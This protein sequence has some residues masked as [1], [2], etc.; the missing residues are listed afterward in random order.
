MHHNCEYDQISSYHEKDGTSQQKDSIS[1]YKENSHHCPSSAKK[2]N[3][4]Y[5]RDR[6]FDLDKKDHPSHIETYDQGRLSSFDANLVNDNSNYYLNERNNRI[7]VTAQSRNKDENLY[8][9]NTLKSDQRH[10]LHLL[11]KNDYS[12][13]SSLQRHCHNERRKQLTSELRRFSQM[14]LTIPNHLQ[15]SNSYG[16]IPIKTKGFNRRLNHSDRKRQK[17]Y[18]NHYPRSNPEEKKGNQ[19]CHRRKSVKF[20]KKKLKNLSLDECQEY[21]MDSTNCQSNKN[22]RA[23][24]NTIIENQNE[25]INDANDVNDNRE[26][27]QIPF[28]MNNINSVPPG[29]IKDY[30]ALVKTYR[31]SSPYRNYESDSPIKC[32]LCKTNQDLNNYVVFFPCEHVCVC[33]DCRFVKRIGSKGEGGWKFCPLCH[34]EIKLMLRRVKKE[35]ELQSLE[36]LR[37]QYWNWV[38]EVKPYLNP[39]FLKQFKR[40]S[41]ARIKTA[42]KE[43][44]DIKNG[45]I[46]QNRGKAGCVPACIIS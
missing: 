15:M 45:G 30:M 29:L 13:I 23:S 28:Y 26:R 41:T 25:I 22:L 10:N 24:S 33:D 21:V 35:G 7:D 42:T 11:P 2:V 31:K 43:A 39:K 5:Y 34:E 3:A 4:A 9:H 6:P 16:F 20:L 12:K 18:P 38:N 32:I 8:R 19:S 14:K 27:Q 17:I 37:E 36:T 1:Q 46:K 44:V 40:K